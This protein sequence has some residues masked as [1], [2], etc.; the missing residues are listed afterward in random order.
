[1]SSEVE[2]QME[3]PAG[4]PERRT[5]PGRDRGPL[6]GVLEAY[7]LLILLVLIGVFFSVLPA[8]SDTFLTSANMRILVSNQVVPAIV[9]LAALIP[10]VCNE[11]DLSVGAITGVAAI[12]VASMLFG[13]FAVPVALVLGV[14][15]GAG[16]GIVNALLVTRAGVNGVITTLGMSTLLAGVVQ[17]KTGGSGVVG[18][19]PQTITDFGANNILGI[20]AVAWA[21]L[22][23]A[24]AVHFLL[25]HTPYGRQL[26]ALGSNP[27]A[28]QL[29]GLRTRWL[30]GSTFMLAGLLA[31][32]A[33]L[34]YVARAG[35]AD[36]SVGPSFTLTGL[37][38]AFLSAAAIRPGKFNVG[39]TIVAVFFLAILNNGLNLAG[40]ATH[41]AS[42]VNGGALIAGVALAMYLSRRR[43]ASVS[44]R[45]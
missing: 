4:V 2:S 33:G 25:E 20:P 30:I 18:D 9:A 41:V 42:Y 39:G 36:P 13:S 31:G 22:V 12:F 29:V 32:I 7:A 45:A 40:A 23:I 43:S 26:Y 11:L 15:I 1:M 38:A 27:T 21:L 34:V 3:A 44:R 17:Q 8:T 24:L 35:G 6:L 14:L 5:A 37:A 19:L 28:A 16:I 10:L